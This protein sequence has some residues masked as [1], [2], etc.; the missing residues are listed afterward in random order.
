MD[1]S[2]S[3]VLTLGF[4]SWGSV[5]LVVTLGFGIGAGGGGTVIDGPYYV[6]AN[7]YHTAGDVASDSYL[8]GPAK[9]QTYVAGAKQ[10]DYR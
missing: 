7:Q 3:S 1:G 5:N 2:P 6:A 8:A 4:G 10:G 9:A